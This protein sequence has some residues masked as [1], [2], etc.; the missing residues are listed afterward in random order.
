M[1]RYTEALLLAPDWPVLL[2]NRAL[3]HKHRGRWDEV[4]SDSRRALELDSRNMKVWKLG[5]V[6]ADV[7]LS[8]V[9]CALL[10]PTDRRTQTLLCCRDACMLVRGVDLLRRGT[11]TWVRR[12]GKGTTSLV[13]SSI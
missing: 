9:L 12:C 5:A 8:D 10:R 11:T 13:A 4:E 6:L 2:V 3:C 1:Q 7:D